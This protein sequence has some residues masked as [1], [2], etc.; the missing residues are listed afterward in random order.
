MKEMDKFRFKIMSAAYTHLG[1]EWRTDQFIPFYR[2]VPYDRIYFPVAGSGMVKCNGVVHHLRRGMML[3][4]PGFAETQVNCENSL[5]KY[6]V[7]FNVFA[8]NSDLDFFAFTYDCLEYELKEDEFPFLRTLFNKLL[9]GFP[10][11][12]LW[13]DAVAVLEAQSALRLLTAPFL[14]KHFVRN[15]DFKV[16]KLLELL[17]FI[18]RHLPE[19]LTLA[20]LAHHAGVHPHYLTGLF[21]AR[22]GITPMAYVRDRRLQHAVN[23]LL[24]GEK[25]IGEVIAEIGISNE[26]VFNKMFRRRFGRTPREL[27][28]RIRRK[29]N[30]TPQSEAPGK[31]ASPF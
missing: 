2:I 29:T 16:P 5:D 14:L 25:T 30:R 19:K 12:T 27:C 7:H 22:F 1:P 8:E 13:K 21:R 28:R 31:N 4:I 10:G 20:D 6:W 26:Q 15:T 23:L 9:H 3:L 11:G 24:P 18:E 17:S